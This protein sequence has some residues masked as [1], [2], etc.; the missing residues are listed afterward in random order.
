MI[1]LFP[2]NMR[3]IA[4]FSSRMGVHLFTEQ[5][6]SKKRKVYSINWQV[7][8]GIMIEK[9]KPNDVNEAIERVMNFARTGEK[10]NIPLHESYGHFLAEDLVAD[11][12][13][14][15]FDRSPYDG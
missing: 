7:R 1:S 14:P 4:L 2:L 8:R 13:V 12:H 6:Q 10:V 9:R 5:I 15:P 3:H 11:H